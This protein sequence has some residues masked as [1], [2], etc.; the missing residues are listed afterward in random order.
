MENK[1]K[2]MIQ[3][4]LLYGKTLWVDPVINKLPRDLF[5]IELY[6]KQ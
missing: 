4:I 2:K 5:S 6:G 3:E 1:N